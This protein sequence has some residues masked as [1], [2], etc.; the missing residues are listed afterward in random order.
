MIIGKNFFIIEIPKTGTSFLRNYFKKYKNII[1]TTHHDTVE[2]NPKLNLLKKKYRISVIRSP[3]LWYL[4]FWKWSCLKKNISPLYKDLTSQRLKIKRLKFNSNIFRYIA[5]QITKDTSELKK[6][7]SDINSKKN[8]NR[9]LEILLN[10]KYKNLIGSDFSF[11][12]QDKLGYMT[13][14]FFYQNVLR[15]D[16]NILFKSNLNFSKTIKK[17]DSKIFTNYYFKTES[18]SEDLKKFLKK[19]GIKENTIKNIDKNESSEQK[20]YNFIN[21]FSK[22]NLLLIEKKENYI[23]KKFKYKKISKNFFKKKNK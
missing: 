8:F 6:L 21:F 1:I 15:K 4:S 5:S 10:S 22:K 20:K 2:H 12:P 14:Y 3:Y 17:L 19:N 11:M 23:F 16:Y 7:F 9:V 13:H 18:L